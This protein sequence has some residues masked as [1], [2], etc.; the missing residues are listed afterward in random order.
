MI[1]LKAINSSSG[2]MTWVMFWGRPLRRSIINTYSSIRHGALLVLYMMH[3]KCYQILSIYANI[4][5]ISF[6]INADADADA[7]G[8]PEYIRTN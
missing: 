6:Y 1:P 4:Q 3:I 7:D 8:M 5:R 2:L